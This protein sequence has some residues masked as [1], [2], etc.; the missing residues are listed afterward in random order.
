MDGLFDTGSVPPGEEVTI[1]IDE[2]GELHYICTIHP[3]RMMGSFE[4]S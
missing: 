2:T 1:T 4:V 3:T